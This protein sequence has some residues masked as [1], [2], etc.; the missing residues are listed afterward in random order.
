LKLTNY[1]L[2]LGRAVAYYP[3]LKKVTGSTTATILFCQLLYWTPISKFHGWVYKT[4]D[5]IEE[6][7][8]LTENE[9]RTA[10]KCL[11]ELGILEKKIQ[12]LDH[13]TGYKINQAVFNRLWEET[14][15][16]K[17]EPVSKEEKQAD[18]KFVQA[19]PLELPF[20]KPNQ[21]VMDKRDAEAKATKE[22]F[23][24]K[25]QNKGDIIDG[26]VAMSKESPG[27][28]KMEKTEK[29][30]SRIETRL[31]VNTDNMKW[32]KFIEFAYNRQELDSQ[33][34]DKFIDYALQEGFNPVYWTPEKMQTLWPQAFPR[35][36]K[37]E[38]D[39]SYV[40]KYEEYKEKEVA[41]MPRDLLKKRDI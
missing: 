40:P 17:S 27:I 26:M 16:K 33:H 12:P 36:V 29:I 39:E 13:T 22:R 28:I 6:E 25:V 11:I 9:Q 5:E 20:D 4:A 23:L 7:T 2:D 37:V 34:V 1:I 10:K 35:P 14:S 3:N 41:P 8:G 30:R 19:T 31:N 15:G 21:E 38:V 32:L 24:N 18:K